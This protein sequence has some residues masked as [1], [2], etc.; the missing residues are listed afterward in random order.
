MVNKFIA[1][2][3]MSCVNNA[4]RR[5]KYILIPCLFAIFSLFTIFLPYP[6]LAATA[7]QV[8]F[9]ENSREIW[10]DGTRD[11]LPEKPYLSGDYIMVPLRPLAEKLGGQVQWE[12]GP[13]ET[14]KVSL[15]NRQAIIYPGSKIVFYLEGE[16][17][18]A[19][20]LPA[21]I[22][23]VGQLVFAPAIMFYRVFNIPYARWPEGKAYLLGSTNRPPTA[24]FEVSQPAYAGQPLHYTVKPQDPEGDPIVEERW[25]GRQEVFPEEGLYTVTLQVKDSRGSW[26]KPFSRT[27]KVLSA[28]VTLQPGDLWPKE[29]ISPT[30]T[31]K[32]I[33]KHTGPILLFS[34]S[35]EYIERPGILYRDEIEG[36]ARLYFWHAI[37]SPLTFRIY[38]LA[39][40]PGQ[41][42]VELT[43][44]K[45]G[46]SGPSN[47]VYQ[48]AKE[49]LIQYFNAT[50]SRTLRLKPGEALILNK[51]TPPAVR[52]QVVH[53]IM[54]VYATGKLQIL[55]IALPTTTDVLKEYNKLPYLLADGI[56]TRG[57]FGP[58]DIEIELVLTGQETGSLILADGQEDEFLPGKG[59]APSLTGNYGAFYKLKLLPIRDTEVFLVPV[60][61][62]FGGIVVLEG[63]IIEVP[64]KGF[65]ET[66]EQAIFLGKLKANRPAEL[67]FIP[68]G[69]SCLPVK[70][71]F[72]PSL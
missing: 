42:E 35:P 39:V 59:S 36:E 18:G 45:E 46:Y 71:V 34:D 10:I 8:I 15:G 13:P 29:K 44:E 28:P 14:I 72:K 50:Q 22:Q 61:G 51:I 3:T 63:N 26:S 62:Y 66:P 52:H 40:N 49:A 65:V 11:E 43:I 47:N 7:T 31:Y 68:P 41:R 48:V 19:E 54:D 33:K 60:S 23:K 25:I 69:G 30:F 56:H 9:S 1:H 5:S 24:Y 70:L 55:F 58:S 37:Q 6:A 2:K 32:P 4:P 64:R 67:Y 12:P 20:I 21:E 57:T 27:I 53:G 16:Q 17:P 38:V